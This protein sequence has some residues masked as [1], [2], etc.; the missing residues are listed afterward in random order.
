MIIHTSKK[1]DMEYALSCILHGTGRYDR[2]M[3]KETP[4]ILRVSQQFVVRLMS[5]VAWVPIGGHVLQLL[6]A[7]AFGVTSERPA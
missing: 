2:K 7:F 6:L 3:A 1:G 5:K 4:L